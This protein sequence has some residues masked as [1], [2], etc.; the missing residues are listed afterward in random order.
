MSECTKSLEEREIRTLAYLF[1]RHLTDL[2]SPKSHSFIIFILN[3]RRYPAQQPRHHAG[4]PETAL[5]DFA[6]TY[7]SACPSEVSRI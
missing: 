1:H 6:R 7:C 2:P 3:L 5:A 4:I